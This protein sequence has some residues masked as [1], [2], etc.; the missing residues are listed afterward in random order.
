LIVCGHYH[1]VMLGT[2]GGVPVWVSPAISDLTDVTC[3]D[4]LR[5]IAGSGVSRIELAGGEHV[6]SVIPIPPA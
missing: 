1:H 3:P 5:M 6:L 4:E 2:V